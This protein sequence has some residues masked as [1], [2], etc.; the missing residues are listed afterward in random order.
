[1][2][3]RYL[4]KAKR[5]D[6]GKWEIGYLVKNQEWAYIVKPL[7]NGQFDVITVNLNTVCQCTG[8]K[9]KNGNLIWE[10][11]VVDFKTSKA[12]VISDKAEW[13]IKWIKDKDTILRK[14]LHFWTNEDDWKCEVIGNTFDHPELLES[15]E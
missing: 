3:D 12:F 7:E 13:R 2:N 1:M 8:L 5:K 14:D 15:E 10:N 11:D 6:N 9:D 4:Y